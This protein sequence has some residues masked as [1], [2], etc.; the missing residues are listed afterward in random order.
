MTTLTHE[1]THI[2]MPRAVRDF[3]DACK[4]SDEMRLVF[5]WLLARNP[6]AGWEPSYSQV[7]RDFDRWLDREHPRAPHAA[8]RRQARQSGKAARG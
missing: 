3:L 5:H 8:K 4:D 7:A 1:S 2:A 6:Y